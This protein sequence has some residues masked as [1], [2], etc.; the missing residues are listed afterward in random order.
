MNHFKLKGTCG[1]ET[2]R[3][4]TSHIAVVILLQG[5]TSDFEFRTLRADH[6]QP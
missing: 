2:S 1:K 4:L 6:G 5:R 3:M